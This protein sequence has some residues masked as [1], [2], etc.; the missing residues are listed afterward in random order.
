[1]TKA[2]NET[3][4]QTENGSSLLPLLWWTVYST[5]RDKNQTEKLG[6]YIQITKAHTS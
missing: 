3:T 6:K 4:T 5:A 1:M 2:N